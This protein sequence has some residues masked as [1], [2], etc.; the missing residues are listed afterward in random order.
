VR[1]ARLAPNALP[2]G[3]A[4]SGRTGDWLIQTDQV[5]AVV[6]GGGEGAEAAAMHGVLADLSGVEWQADLLRD[7]RVVVRIGESEVPLYTTSVEPIAGKPPRLAIVQHCG[8]PASGIELRTEVVAARGQRWIELVTRAKNGSGRSFTGVR[9]GDR[10]RWLRGM[11]FLPGVDTPQRAKPEPARWFAISSSRQSYAMVFADGP[12]DVSSVQLTQDSAEELALSP[13]VELPAGAVVEYKRMIVVAEGGVAAVAEHAWRLLGL[14]V[15]RVV[16]KLEPV[17]AWARIEARNTAGEL[18]I[19]VE[20]GH[21]GSFDF[22]LPA[23][24]H[25][26]VLRTPGGRDEEAVTLAGGDEARPRFIVAKPSVLTYR[27][28]DPKGKPLP[29]RLVVRGV[30]PTADPDLGPPYQA[31]GAKISS[32]TASGVGSLSLPEGRYDILVTH[33]M[34]YSIDRQQIEVGAQSGATLRATLTRIIDT[35]G[36]VACDFHLHASPSGD[37]KV[38]LPD[39]VTSLLAE[40]IELAVATDHNHVTDYGPILDTIGARSSVSTIRGVEITTRGWGH[41]N[42]FPLPEGATPPPYDV[43]PMAI[44]EAVRSAAPGA[45]IQ[46]NHPRMPGDI[47]YFSVG[48]FGADGGPREGFSFDFD[49]LEIFNGFDLSNLGKIERNLDDWYS[50]ISAGRLYTAVGNSDSHDLARQ[51]AGYPRTYVRMNDDRLD[52]LRPEA[53]AEAVKAGRAFVTNGPFVDLK[54]AGGRP[55]DLVR[56]AGGRAPVEVVV[57]AAPWVDVTRVTLVVAGRV[58]QEQ[59]IPRSEA[60]ERYRMRSEVTLGADSWVVAIVR[61]DNEM[62][63]VLPDAG[64]KPMAFTN[65]VYLDA[66]GDGAFGPARQRA[67]SDAGR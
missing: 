54:V 30:A 44:F 49:T 7:Q 8:G 67:A 50:L 51:T 1:V 18:V 45:V 39:R 36:L 33:G 41:F 37:S 60:I 11:Q 59:A 12:A 29:A 9:L 34:E 24:A 32:Y 38:S 31:S 6:G 4:L 66:D 19:A 35:P 61:G 27:V 22:A 63:A 20:V 26:L 5:R 48:G 57:R 55:G 17:P 53:V 62:E 16:G 14:R 2:P 3:P 56:A 10:V 28:N 13:A 58:T 21:D 23:G 64:A 65:P 52:A 42:A 40:G 15:G 43:A 47:G 25:R 46:V